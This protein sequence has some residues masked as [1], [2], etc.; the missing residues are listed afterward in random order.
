MVIIKTANDF[1]SCPFSKKIIKPGTLICLFNMKQYI[2][3]KKQIY[4][5]L[6]I[7]PDDIIELIIKKTNY[8]KY[9]NRFGKEKI[10]NWTNHLN[11]KN[12]KHKKILKLIKNNYSSNKDSSDS[13]ESD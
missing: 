3:F 5:I 4:Y 6:S 7:L 2:S 11:N 8:S 10:S 9:I 13:S 12:C 1:M